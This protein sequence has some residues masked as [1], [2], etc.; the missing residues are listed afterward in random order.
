VIVG[1][2]Q[3]TSFS[4]MEF[5]RRFSDHCRGEGFLRA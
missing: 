2:A 3:G 1:R 4:M 5:P